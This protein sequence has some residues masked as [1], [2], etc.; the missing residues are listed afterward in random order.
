MYFV[1]IVRQV[2]SDIL[3]KGGREREKVREPKGDPEGDTWRESGEDVYRAGALIVEDNIQRRNAEKG[4]VD[5]E[6]DTK[7][8][9]NDGE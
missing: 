1:Y 6:E 2:A 7:S 5:Y 8:L 4:D 9:T 3:R